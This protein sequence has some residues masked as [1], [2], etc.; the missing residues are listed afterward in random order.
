MAQIFPGEFQYDDSMVVMPPVLTGRY[1]P[2]TGMSS[3]SALGY[4]VPW[5]FGGEQLTPLT[6]SVGTERTAPG[7]SQMS[8]LAT[9][10]LLSMWLEGLGKVAEA[11]IPR[12]TIPGQALSPDKLLPAAG[13]PG[14]M[15]ATGATGATGAQGDT[16]AE[17]VDGDDGVPIMFQGSYASVAA[18]ITDKGAL[19]DGWSYY[20]TTDN[21]SYVYYSPSWYQMTIDGTDGQDG[22]DG[23]EGADGEDGL[24]IVWHG[25]A[26][27]PDPGWE[28]VNHVY[29]DTDNGYVYIYT[30]AAWELMVLDGSDGVEGAQGVQGVEGVEGA[31]GAEGAEGLSVFITYHDNAIDDEPSA[32]T[33]DGTTGGWHTAA[34]SESNWMGQKVAAS[35]SEGT[36]GNPI[37]IKGAQG[38]TGAAGEDGDRVPILSEFDFYS[39]NPDAGKVSWLGGHIYVDDT[40]INMSSGG[41]TALKYIYW[42]GPTA[43]VLSATDMLSV[44][45][46]RALDHW[47][48]CINDGG[49]A[50]PAMAQRLINAGMIVATSLSAIHADL[51][52]I[53]AGEIILSALDGSP[54]VAASARTQI[55]LDG[56]GLYGRWRGSNLPGWSDSENGA[57]ND[58]NSGWRKII[59]I[60]DN[61]VKLSFDSFD[62]GDSLPISVPVQLPGVP[63]LMK[64]A[65]Y[66]TSGSWVTWASIT[67]AISEAD[68]RM[69][70]GVYIEH[71][72]D[73]GGSSYAE[74]RVYRVDSPDVAVWSD[75]SLHSTDFLVPDAVDFDVA[76]ADGES[77]Y[78]EV[79]HKSSSGGM[80]HGWGGN[81]TIYSTEGRAVKKT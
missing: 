35:A 28:I 26:E 64:E 54:T 29:K 7:A 3:P 38:D 48:V 76:L 27:S 47:L 43:T 50:N 80:S 61:E 78:L 72:N 24:D 62:S 55:K 1:N 81:S 60:T 12:L 65:D 44:A 22:E 70:G 79:K 15:G 34:T 63:L 77:Y 69:Q 25:E 36:W 46:N 57:G 59:D 4:M 32:P 45:M 30:G 20:N 17:G 58:Y 31:E 16:G 56:T 37:L 39:N 66:S 42:D 33:G 6:P 5:G 41:N 71:R 74:V 9:I 68:Q 2:N 11:T 52:N 49:T 13:L 8:G 23:A 67:K 53:N 10:E 21:K 51:G 14:A 75:T 19:Q 73:G 40:E 18:L